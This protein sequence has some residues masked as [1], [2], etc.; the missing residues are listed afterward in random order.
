[1]RKAQ[2]QN[3]IDFLGD[4]HRALTPEWYLEVGTQTGRS[5]ALAEAN[6]VAIDPEFRVKQDVIKAKGQLVLMQQTSD[7]FFASGFLGQTGLTFDLAFLD[8]MHLYEYL[9]RDFIN[10][11]RHMAPGAQIVMHDCMP[12]NEN[13][14]LRDRDEVET[15]AWTGDVWKVIPI[16]KEYRPDLKVHLFDAAP[17][18][19]VVVENLDPTNRVLEEKYDEIRSRFD[20]FEACEATVNAFEITPTAQSPWSQAATGLSFAIKTPVPRPAVQQRWGDYH[21]AMGLMA[22]LERA[23]HRARVQ[24]RKHWARVEDPDEI[25]IVLKGGSDYTPARDRKTLFWLMSKTGLTDEEIAG[26]DHFFVAGQPALK[27]VAGRVGAERA[28]LL[29]Q[30][31]DPNRMAPPDAAPDR[32]SAVFVGGPRRGMR[33]MVRYALDAAKDIRVW[34]KHWDAT[35]ASALAVAENLPNEDVSAVYGSAA[36]VLNDHTK[37]MRFAGIP[38]NRVFDGLACGAPVIT[39]DVGWY[40]EDIAPYLYVVHDPSEFSEALEAA[41]NESVARRME[42]IAFANQ[43]RETHSFDARAAEI[44]ARAAA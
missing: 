33:P 40:P 18:G 15:R 30:A 26:G 42:R 29:P 31:F 19:L 9:L 28:S 22:A 12:W 34:G 27:T 32:G 17:T 6:S 7:A 5:L 24:T 21:F 39:D 1:M 3:Y 10:A 4:M 43:M 2:G 25:D 20:R 38:S 8:G 16:L 35:D 37:A 41:E 14:A 23:G 44:I 13:M 36:A 11:E